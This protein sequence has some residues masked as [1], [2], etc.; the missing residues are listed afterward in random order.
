MHLNHTLDQQ[1]RPSVTEFFFLPHIHFDIYK[2]INIR[3]YMSA[4]RNSKA[5]VTESVR[6][7]SPLLVETEPGTYPQNVLLPQRWM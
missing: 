4:V 5:K 3:Q 6:E 2:Q 1:K 7:G